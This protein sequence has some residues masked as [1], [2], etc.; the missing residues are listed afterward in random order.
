MRRTAYNMAEIIKIK[1]GL[2]IP[3]KGEAASTHT[4]DKSTYLFGITPDDFPGHKWKSA[5][6][7]GDQV[8]VGSPLLYS[9][10]TE[11]VK[12]TSP[13]CG[14][15]QE[16]RRGERRHILAV[17][18]E[19]SAAGGVPTPDDFLGYDTAKASSREEIMECL[20]ASGMFA[21][22]RQRPF[23]VVPDPTVAPRDI[24]VTG[25]DSAP[26]AP[27]LVTRDMFPLLE[28][29]LEVLSHLTDGNVYIGVPYD[30]QFTSRHARVYEFRGPHPAG[31]V[32]TQI[33]AIRPVNRGE[34]VWTLSAR[35]AVRI[36]SLFETGHI[37]A[38]ASVCVCGDMASDPH[39]IDTRVGASLQSL[40]AGQ[41]KSGEGEVR[42]ISG[43][44]LTGVKVDAS[45]D[46]LRYPYRQVTLIAEGD[47]ADEF[48]GWATLR[49]D[50]YS[51]KHSFLSSLLGKH[52]NYKFDSRLRG[53]KRAMILSGEMDKVFPMDIYPEFLLKAIMAGDIE[54]ME[55]LG[56]YEVAPED[57][58]LPEFVDTSKQPLQQ[59]VRDGLEKLRDEL[60]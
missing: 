2:D 17:T 55:Q 31:N 21:L 15:V 52:G 34:T 50:H 36:G 5:V 47:H 58:A 27:Q 46:F 19:A 53:G 24:F 40:L 18:V 49:P 38:A 6:K 13:V 32:G 23:D 9:K 8:F 20:C 44:P 42:V 41:R 10:D 35:T 4:P 59:I 12:L 56:V 57:F 16:V 33:A 37:D 29:G 3:I 43:N 51:V 45:S 30:S 14:I 25:F 54:K 22:L 7:A 48:M 60:A 39:Y 1:K 28:K 26:L 11:H